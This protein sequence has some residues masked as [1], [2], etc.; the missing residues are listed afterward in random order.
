MSFDKERHLCYYDNIY[1]L[2]KD[3]KFCK[4]DELIFMTCIS[5]FKVHVYRFL[6]QTLNISVSKYEYCSSVSSSKIYIK[7]FSQYLL[8]MIILYI[9]LFFLFDKVTEIK[10]LMAIHM[11][12]LLQHSR[13]MHMKRQQMFIQTRKEDTNNFRLTMIIQSPDIRFNLT[14]HM[15]V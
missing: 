13:R 3:F 15:I 4:V 11:K 8:E 9:F 12:N 5:N 7:L 2:R 6:I 14:I 10:T 1:E